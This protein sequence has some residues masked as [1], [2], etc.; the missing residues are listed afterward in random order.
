MTTRADRPSLARC[1]VKI[2]LMPAGAL[3]VHQLRFL[4]AYGGG[5][6]VALARQGHSYL[7]SLVPWIVALIALA[8]GGFLWRLG[9]ALRGHTSAP[10]FT[11]SLAALWALCTVCLVAIY[12]TQEGLEGMF[13]TGHPAALA[14]IFGHGG[15]WAVPAAASVG[16]VLAAVF[17]GARWILDEV[18]LRRRPALHVRDRGGPSLRWPRG[19]R[20]ALLPPLA[21]GW[22][23]RGPPR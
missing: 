19:V 2:A 15:W 16:L 9:R 1:L 8:A 22:S 23:G 18:T 12:A 21:G 17:H 20:L 6:G 4:L 10:R 13:A 7:D 3:A 5:A 14:G 11:L